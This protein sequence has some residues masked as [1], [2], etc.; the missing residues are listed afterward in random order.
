M[1]PAMGMVGCRPPTGP[2]AMRFIREHIP[3]EDA[4]DESDR[5]P[6]SHL[7]PG[8][9]ERFDSR[10]V[11]ITGVWPGGWAIIPAIAAGCGSARPRPGRCQPLHFLKLGESA[12][13]ADERR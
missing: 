6:L 3:G 7:N 11:T 1:I 8:R 4:N 13:D 10:A 2:L 9:V 5:N 12:D